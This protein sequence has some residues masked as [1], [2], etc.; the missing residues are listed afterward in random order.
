MIP[1]P[2][3]LHFDNMKKMLQKL[4]CKRKQLSK[5][6][7]SESHVCQ[8]P[9]DRFCF[10]SFESTFFFHRAATFEP[11]VNSK[12]KTAAIRWQLWTFHLSAISRRSWSSVCLSTPFSVFNLNC[13]SGFLSLAHPA[14]LAQVGFHKMRGILMRG[15][16]R[17]DWGCY[18]SLWAWRWMLQTN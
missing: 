13:F 11:S 14:A 18:C 9:H 4:L 8:K 17:G 12:L 1:L 3:K 7:D 10:P 6:R 2:Y 16:F 15:V 5:I